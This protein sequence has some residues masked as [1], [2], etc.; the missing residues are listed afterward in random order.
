MGQFAYLMLAAFIV[1][2]AMFLFGQQQDTMVAD[3]QLNYFQFKDEARAAAHSG[4]NIT[5]G[6]LARDTDP[7]VDSTRYRLPLTSY[8]R[9]TYK[10]TVT[11]SGTPL[12]DTVDVIAKGFKSYI[13][14]LGKGD[15]TTHTIQ[16]RVVRGVHHGSIPPGFRNALM[17]DLDLT[18]QGDMSITSLYPGE[19]ASVHSNGTLRTIGNSYLVEGYGTYTTGIDDHHPGGWQ[20]NNDW[21]GAA[22]NTFY[23]D[24]IPLPIPD[25]D[26]WLNNATYYVSGDFEID[27][28]TFS[29]SDFAAWATAEGVPE[30]GVADAPF[31]LYIDGNLTLKNRIEMTGYGILAVRGDLVM[32]PNG[33]D[34]GFIG[35]VEEYNTTAGLF[36]HGDI[37]IQ[38]NAIITG[39]LFSE[40]LIQFRGTPTITGGV[41]AKESEFDGGGTPNIT[42]VGPGAGLIDEGFPYDDPIGPVI[43]AYAEW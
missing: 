24:S 29:Y 36:A 18:L 2:G 30:R 25:W 13:N 22:G 16:A 11:P 10:T 5:L 7:W 23:R 6:N 37:D 28:N 27:G 41:I 35:Q 20:P 3:K 19:N 17:S 8:E 34:G 39:T 43:V 9:A 21:N 12:G 33:S 38:G 15:D 31:I 1:T 32:E 40:Q 42:W 26:A 4:F 14:R